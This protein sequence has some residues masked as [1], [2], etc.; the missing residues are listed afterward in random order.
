MKQ[1]SSLSLINPQ[2]LAGDL[3]SVLPSRSQ[4]V[5]KKRFGLEN[6]H[7]QTLQQVGDIYGITRERIR[8][9]I[10]ASLQ[11][12]KKKASL[13]EVSDFW[14][15]VIVVLEKSGGVEEEK[16][17]FIRL[18]KALPQVKR[19]ESAVNFL[20]FL[21]PDII[22]EREDS[23]HNGFW[24]LASQKKGDL[25]KRMKTIE[26]YFTQSKEPLPLK[27]TFQSI[28]KKV[29]PV[30]TL[31]EL[32]AYLRISKKIGMNPFGEYG[33]LFS[34]EIEPAGTKDRAYVVMKHHQ[35]PSHFSEIA[36]LI[37]QSKKLP[38]SPTL[39]SSTWLKT[40]KVQTV[41]NELIKDKRFVL[42]GRGIYALRDW[43]YK[44]GR[45]VDVIKEILKKATR[46]LTQE[47]I[48]KRVKEQRFAQENTIIL[49]LHNKKYFKKLPDKRYTLIR[50]HKVLEI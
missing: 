6:N 26:K 48:I 29:S 22:F 21:S 34:S 50:S 10:E 1:V 45:V 3:I 33:V 39:L 13:A 12:I 44:P 17:L 41:H 37:N 7:P 15:K 27:E 32:T 47:E 30:L 38:V 11:I 43:G 9:I 35:K 49:N 31:E 24:H 8:Q 5:L 20:L 23:D 25:I 4:A 36:D 40:V 42:I 16:E 18:E 14:K 19:K 2:K 28:E 46:P